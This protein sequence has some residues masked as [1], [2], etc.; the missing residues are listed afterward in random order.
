MKTEK[1]AARD[2]ALNLETKITMFRNRLER[3]DLSHCSTGH[4][5]M[6]LK[7]NLMQETVYFLQ[8][9]LASN[10]CFFCQLRSDGPEGTSPTPECEKCTYADVHR[11]CGEPGS[12]YHLLR[13]AL[14]RVRALVETYY[15]GT[16]KMPSKSKPVTLETTVVG[17]DLTVKIL[18]W[19]EDQRGKINWSSSKE[20]SIYSFVHPE[21]SSGCIYLPGDDRSLDNDPLRRRFSDHKTLME[22]LTKMLEAV[23]EFN[24]TL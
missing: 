9:L 8:D 16:E 3:I 1:D 7:K 5:I 4:E 23:E 13:D 21:L 10:S 24:K 18:S 22:Y 17:L 12:D 14:N 2:T 20:F 6:I 19:P 15:I 11:I